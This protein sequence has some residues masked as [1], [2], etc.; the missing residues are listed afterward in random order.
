MSNSNLHTSAIATGGTS[1][2][3]ATCIGGKCEY[4]LIESG[5][6]AKV[7]YHNMVCTQ[8][9]Y[10]KPDLN[11][12]LEPFHETDKPDGSKPERSPFDD[13]ETA[14]FVGDFSMN[15]LGNGLV[16][17]QRV[18]A[19]VPEEHIEPYGLFS[20]VLP[21]YTTSAISI[22]DTNVSN[23]EL[24]EQYGTDTETWTDRAT[25]DF[26]D[27]IVFGDTEDDTS[28][29][30][31]NDS[32]LDWK[33]YNFVRLQ[34]KFDYTSA[35]TVQLN[36]SIIPKGD[37]GKYTFSLTSG[38]RKWYFAEQNV[39]AEVFIKCQE[40]F[41]YGSSRYWRESYR[42]L[43]VMTVTDVTE[44][45][46]GSVSVTAHTP[47]FNLQQHHSEY[48][49]RNFG[50]GIAIGRLTYMRASGVTPSTSMGTTTY[51][52]TLYTNYIIQKPLANTSKYIQVP[53]F[54]RT[55]Q[56]EE[57]CPAHIVYTYVKTDEPQQIKLQEKTFFPFQL[58]ST[59]TPTVEKYL[60]DKA[61]GI[62]FNAENQFIERYMGNIYRLGQI[63][64]TI[65]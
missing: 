64:S 37:F 54:S 40:K 60:A 42:S 38:Y 58:T 29:T 27:D 48:V 36:T 21:A 30:T 28:T 61:N 49:L 50:R 19:Q 7:Y 52:R 33:D 59:T 13:D 46:D 16:G 9:K 53:S 10:E 45:S 15:P 23:L 1:F 20:R 39:D 11:T 14:F 57:N 25:G 43:G 62:P 47:P 8:D 26:N 32:N 6:E 31:V 65:I 4:P 41:K 44:N 5:N 63:R 34:Y 22:D 55:N 12:T 2:D 56:T 35:S 24:K 17:F 51:H 18:Y 3:T